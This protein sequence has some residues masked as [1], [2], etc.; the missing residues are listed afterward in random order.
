MTD[1][2]PLGITVDRADSIAA[3]AVTLRVHGTPMPQGSK[4]PFRRGDKIVLVDGRRKP[5]RESHAAWR[6]AVATAARDHLDAGGRH[7]PA[8][9]PVEGSIRLLLAKP[10]SKPRRVV[11][12]TV[13]PDLV[14]LVRTVEDALKDGGLIADDAQIVRLGIEKRYAVEEAPG[15]VVV[16]QEVAG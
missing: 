9:V 11:W 12:P 2:L 4:T 13:R 3:G 8:G 16:L 7:F 15:C 6:Q 10:K 14:K 1:Q 5:A